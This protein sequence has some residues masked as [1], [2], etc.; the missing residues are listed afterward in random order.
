MKYLH[1]FILFVF[2]SSPGFSQMSAPVEYGIVQDSSIRA[3]PKPKRGIYQNFGELKNNEP[4]I[5]TD[6]RESSRQGSIV[7][8]QIR[9][10]KK[11]VKNAYAFSDGK[12][13][14]INA[15]YYNREVY[16]V[17]LEVSG[18]YAL[19][20]EGGSGSYG[21]D[22]SIGIGPIPGLEDQDFR[23]YV[24]DMETGFI[25]ELTRKRMKRILAEDQ[26]L[27]RAYTQENKL[28]S[29]EVLEKYIQAYNEKTFYLNQ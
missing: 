10:G 21:P 3:F 11:R 2:L 15:R 18:R 17:K 22:A 1:F 8:H 9:I 29:F 27:L 12:S 5:Q 16:Y 26:E 6:F 13:I 25:E 14:Y 28:A 7:K 24:L 20:R 23:A 19:I 4:S